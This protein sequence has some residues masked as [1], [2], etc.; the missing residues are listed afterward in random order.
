[1]GHP[2]LKVEATLDT[3]G[4]AMTVVSSLTVQLSGKD[5]FDTLALTAFRNSMGDPIVS[6]DIRFNS[7]VD[8]NTVRTWVRDQLDT[9]PIV[10]TWVQQALVSWH[11]C[12]HADTAIQNCHTTAYAEW[13]R[14]S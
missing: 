9:H 3:L 12:S 6:A 2:R 14:E 11:Q 7:D 4:H 5:I 1:M 8:R 10:K 13:S